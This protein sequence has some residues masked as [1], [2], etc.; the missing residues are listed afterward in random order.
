MAPPT[1][2]TP[3]PPLAANLVGNRAGRS[4]ELGVLTRVRAWER[5]LL[6]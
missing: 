6:H 1:P 2:M 3:M 4:S 5:G